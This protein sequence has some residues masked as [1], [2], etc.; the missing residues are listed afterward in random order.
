MRTLVLPQGATWDLFDLC[1][2]DA[3]AETEFEATAARALGRAYAG[4]RCV[5][6]GGS[7]DYEGS[8]RRPDLALVARDYSHWFVVE[9][10]LLSHSLEGHV[11]PQMRAL[12]FGEPQDDCALVLARELSL[13]L[14][15]AQTLL[16]AVPRSTIVIANGHSRDWQVALRA[17]DVGY[18]SVSAFKAADGREAFEI[19]G[20]L[21]P[22]TESIGFGVFVSADGALRM[23]RTV[24]LPEGSVQI[25]AEHG[26]VGLWTVRRDERFAW[27]SKDQGRPT[28]PDD[29]RVQLLRNANGRILLRRTDSRTP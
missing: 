17:L 29:A 19:W 24:R 28:L 23:A 12:R 16:R 9:V 25:E 3:P 15:Q 8:I 20:A 21:A 27:I 26:S 6:F 4:Y 14:S 2:P 7:F 22:V 10:E 13:H 1:D 18:L 11:L 5:V